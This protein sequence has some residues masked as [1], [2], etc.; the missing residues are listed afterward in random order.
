M[1]TS[2]F[3]IHLLRFIQRFIF[4]FRF[5]NNFFI[6]YFARSTEHCLAYGVEGGVDGAGD[7]SRHVL[8]HE[9]VR[10]VDKVG[11]VALQPVEQ[12]VI[13]AIHALAKK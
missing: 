7:D 3:L 6:L 9:G 2:T 4:M 12:Q 10:R 13:P 8:E 1:C 5:K 11:R